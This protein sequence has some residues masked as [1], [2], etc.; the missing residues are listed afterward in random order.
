MKNLEAILKDFESI[1]H[2][3]IDESWFVE[4]IPT[5]LNTLSDY[6]LSLKDAILKVGDFAK[7]HLD[8]LSEEEDQDTTLFYYIINFAWGEQAKFFLVLWRDIIFEQQKGQIL[9]ADNKTNEAALKRLYNESKSTLRA[10]ADDLLNVVQK[11][12]KEIEKSRSGKEG[13][14]ATWK[15][16]QNPW[17]IYREQIDKLPKQCK[18]LVK[19]FHELR[20][21]AILFE[22]IDLLIQQS[23]DQ[24]I[25]EINEIKKL[26][27]TNI[28]FI[29]DSIEEESEKKLSKIIHHLEDLETEIKIS[30]HS[31]LFSDALEQLL[32][33]LPAKTQVFVDTQGGMIQFKEINFKRSVKQWLES[34]ILPILYEEWELTENVC[35]G[36]KMSLVN[37]RNR[38]ILLAAENKENVQQDFEKADLNQPLHSFL[39]RISTTLGSLIELDVLTTD[40]VDTI[41]SVSNVYDD[42]PVFLPIP[43]QS[44]INQLK[45]NPRNI[46]DSAWNWVQNRTEFL[47]KIKHQAEIEDALSTSEKVV[48]FIQNR[49][50][51]PHSA[52]YAS[53]FLTH[54]YIGESFRVGRRQE[55]AHVENIVENWRSGFRGAVVI[56]GQRF[57]GKSLFG[58]VVANNFFFPQHVIRLS[59]NSLLKMQGRR[60]HTTAD[61]KSALDYIRKYTLNQPSLV[62]IDDFELW[63]DHEVSLSKNARILRKYIDNYSGQLFFLV[64]MSNWTKAHLNKFYETSKVFQAEINLD[65]MSEQEIR[66][67]ILI[68][69]GATHKNLVDTEGKEVSPQQFRKMTRKIYRSTAGN[70]GESLTRWSA[71]THQIGEENV[72]H[73]YKTEQP[74]MDFVSSD[75]ALLLATIMMK[76]RTN[77]YSLRKLFGPA[78]ADKYQSILQRLISVGVLKR[79]LDGWLEV[80]E[81][82]VNDLGRL[83]EKKNYLKFYR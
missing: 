55:L 51:D 8:I 69:H 44:T 71:V 13:R 6:S 7:E 33:E 4:D 74:L 60:T 72:I 30:N 38:A 70:I 26:A 24:C 42:N 34:E 35:N 1:L 75:S 57:A 61:L 9:L 54:G 73:D 83:L 64:S 78:F 48:R 49:M 52:H 22:K 16:Q 39:K 46:F 12:L 53:I 43:L 81:V 45:L 79:Q 28:E 25:H 50:I 15:L 21:V 82:L 11:E 17:P 47:R 65:K 18:E 62:W 77:E 41:F 40:R 29:G 76:K 59:P 10:A 3:S 27:E 32:V 5:H 67:A 37:I 58:E 20:K 2:R 56:T 80:N 19:N 68:R 23:E 36:M 63:W 14:I 31:S 66:E